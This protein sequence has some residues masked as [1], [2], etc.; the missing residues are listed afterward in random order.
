MFGF[1]ASCY[2]HCRRLVNQPL[3]DHPQEADI[4]N[5]NNS[6]LVPEETFNQKPVKDKKEKTQEEKPEKME[7]MNLER[8]HETIKEEVRA[9]KADV[10]GQ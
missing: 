10:G 4:N 6:E 9:L 5:S 2:C 8:K 3:S 7:N 1:M